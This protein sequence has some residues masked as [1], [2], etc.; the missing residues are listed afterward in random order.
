MANPFHIDVLDPIGKAVGRILKGDTP[1]HEFHGNQWTAG[2]SGSRLDLPST[3][4]P[5]MSIS[6]GSPAGGSMSHAVVTSVSPSGHK[7]TAAFLV[8]GADD[9]EKKLAEAKTMAERVQIIK[10]NPS[11]FARQ[12]DTFVRRA[13]GGYYAKGDR[14]LWSSPVRLNSTQTRTY[15]D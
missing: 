15:M 7:F 14:S 6:T 3:P 2:H 4:T 8:H 9:I 10:D 11:A 12:Q 5:G 13:D 1:G